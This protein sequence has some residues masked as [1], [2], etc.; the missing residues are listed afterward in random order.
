MAG[1]ILLSSFINMIDITLL[2][3]S[4]V[5]RH[6]IWEVSP[7]VEERGLIGAWVKDVIVIFIPKP[8]SQFMMPVE[9]EPGQVR[10]DERKALR[11]A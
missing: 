2:T 9:V 10:W 1:I 6:V 8:D 4:D 7:G 11:R 5:G 3:D